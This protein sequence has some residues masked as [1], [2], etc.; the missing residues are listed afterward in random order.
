MNKK[1][2]SKYYHLSMEIKNLE[3]QIT[4]L[5]NSLVG[6]PE[7]TE[8][9]HGSG[10]GN[11]VEE[12]AMLIINLKNKLEKRKEKALKELTKIETYIANIE[13]AETRLIFTKRYIQFKRWD[14]IVREMCM[15]KSNV[16]RRHQEQLKSNQK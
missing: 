14:D 1:E 13:I 4:E 3:E 6:S 7:L 10:I 9:P 15:S 16:F 5:M 12:K 8:M 2:L 11:P